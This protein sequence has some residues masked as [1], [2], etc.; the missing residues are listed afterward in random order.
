[1]GAW[2]WTVAAVSLGVGKANLF[3]LSR[4][5][6]ATL[7][8]SV[9]LFPLPLPFPFFPLPL[10]SIMPPLAVGDAPFFRD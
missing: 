5:E 6:V 2:V 7:L 9:L 10:L 3:V 1:M 8:L 4:H